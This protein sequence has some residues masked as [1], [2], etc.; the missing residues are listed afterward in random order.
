MRR[1]LSAVMRAPSPVTERQGPEGLILHHATEF[2]NWGAGAGRAKRVLQWHRVNRAI[3]AAENGEDVHFW[4]HPFN[5][6]ENS[7][8]DVAVDGFLLKTAAMRDKDLIDCR[9]FLKRMSILPIERRNVRWWHMLNAAT[10]LA[11]LR[12]ATRPF[13]DNVIVNEYPKSGG[14]WLSQMLSA[15]LGLPFPR[16]RLPMLRS[17]L[18]QCHVVNP[19]GMRKVVVVWRDGR[20]V[21]G[22]ILSSSSYWA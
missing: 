8:L 12:G 5:L 6:A 18:M 17:C 3:A 11:I 9:R 7:G 14:S 20:D 1:F 16:N 2:L 15:S 19:V 13:S 4:L 21:A 22:F 10:R